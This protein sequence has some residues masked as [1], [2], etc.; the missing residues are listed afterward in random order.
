MTS[1]RGM[2]GPLLKSVAN[3]TGAAAK[4]RAQGITAILGLLRKTFEDQSANDKDPI[5]V[6]RRLLQSQ[7]ARREDIRP[8]EAEHR[9]DFRRPAADPLDLH[10]FRDGGFVLHS[11][12]AGEALAAGVNPHLG[13]PKVKARD[14]PNLGPGERLARGH[15]HP[16]AQPD[17]SGKVRS[18]D[19]YLNRAAFADAAG[20]SVFAIT[21]PRTGSAATDALEDGLGPNKDVRR[22]RADDPDNPYR[23]Y[24]ALADIIVVTGESES[25]LSEAAATGKPF[26]I[27]PLPP[28]RTGLRT[29]IAEAVLRRSRKPRIN[30]RGTIRPQRGLQYRCA[31]LIDR[32]WVRPRRD[33]DM[34]HR[35][36]V[37][38]GFARMFG[39][40]SG[41]GERPALHE[42][43]AVAARV[44]EMMGL[45]DD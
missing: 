18:L 10:K 33:L 35:S 36:L 30:K 38:G 43:A 26:L 45:A 42:A 15:E 2:T 14:R 9:V 11:S 25:M 19:L 29:R 22:W 39:R 24:L 28:R 6:T 37:Q 17:Q 7:I 23:G 20:G 4:E 34:L 40:E 27:Y 21:S 13:A 32:G 5:N 41:E 8:T 16:P 31:W 44:R 3:P 1:D 12:E